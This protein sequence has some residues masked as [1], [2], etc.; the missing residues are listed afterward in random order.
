MKVIDVIFSLIAGRFIGFLISDFLKEW[1]IGVGLYYNIFLWL[2][3]PFFALFCL[4]VAYL[5]GTK[6]LFIFQAAKYILV[7]AVATIVDLQLFELLIWGFASV[8]VL[9]FKIVSFLLATFLKYWGNKYWAFSKHEK[10]HSAKEIVQFFVITLGGLVINVIA[11]YYFTKVL[12]P[13]F[14]MPESAWLKLSV[15]LAGVSAALW[16][17]LGYKF[18]VFKK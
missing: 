3:I 8:N 12:G 11:F 13:Q 15:I 10:E 5:I 1:G 14:H 7:G 2:V 18:L 17:F 16:N 4:W 6:F 9:I